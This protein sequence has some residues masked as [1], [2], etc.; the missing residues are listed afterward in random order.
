MDFAREDESYVVGRGTS[1][2]ID[3]DGPSQKLA[4][5]PQAPLSSSLGSPIELKMERRSAQAAGVAR[6]V[7]TAVMWLQA[8]ALPVSSGAD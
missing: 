4:L 5:E 8:G 1:L 7:G 2:K 3:S 6:T